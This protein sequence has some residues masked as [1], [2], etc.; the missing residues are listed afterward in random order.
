MIDQYGDARG[1]GRGRGR[2]GSV[3]TLRI[4]P[5]FGHGHSQ[6][7]NTGGAQSKHGI[8]HA[9]LEDCIERATKYGLTITGLHMHIGSGT[10]MEHSEPRSAGAMEQAALTVGSYR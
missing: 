2:P 9:E 8:W 10:D 5:G 7:V 3:I 1:Q 6:K 4:N